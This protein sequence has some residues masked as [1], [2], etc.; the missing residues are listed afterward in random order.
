[1]EFNTHEIEKHKIKLNILSNLKR[2]LYDVLLY[3]IRSNSK[4][5]SEL[6]L[7]IDKLKKDE[8]EC[9]KYIDESLS[10]NENKISQLKVNTEI[11]KNLFSLKKEL[12]CNT[13]SDTIITLIDYYKH[14]QFSYILSEITTCEI[15]K[16]L[17]SNL[18]NSKFNICMSKGSVNKIVYTTDD[19]IIEDNIEYLDLR[20]FK[21][22]SRSKSEYYS[23]PPNFTLI[24]LDNFF[25]LLFK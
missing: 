16:S 8:F 1:M 15:P 19:I 22:Y 17:E 24:D 13:V 21:S 10:S 6:E 7:I 11:L 3:K 20:N 9:Q 2:D 12:D 23:F 25:K 18:V 14:D 5:Y 4:A